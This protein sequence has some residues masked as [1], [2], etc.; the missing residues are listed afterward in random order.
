M[1]AMKRRY[2]DWAATSL[3]DSTLLSESL[4]Q[5]L[6]FSGNP[7]SRHADGK[8]ARE[9][10]EAA[11]ARCALVLGVGADTLYFTSGGTES[12]NLV[13]QSILFRRGARSIAVSAVEHPSVREPLS[14]LKILDVQSAIIPVAASGCVLPDAVKR[15]L[16]RHPDTA[17]Q[18]IMAV[19]NETGAVADI[20]A[21]AAAACECA[22]RKAPHFHCDAVQALGKMPI[23]LK[24]WDVDSA[25]FSAHKIGG[26]R[27]VGLLY[28]RKKFQ[29]LYSGGEQERGLR[30]GTENLFGALAFAAVLEKYAAA[31]VV[32]TNA[33]AASARYARLID[34]LRSIEGCRIVPEERTAMD[35]RFSPY[36]V[37]AA[38]RGIPGEVLVRAMDD[39]GFSISTGSACSSHSRKRS[40]LE[41]MGVDE[42]TALEAVRLSQGF[43]TS[44]EDID[45]LIE[46]LRNTTR[47]LR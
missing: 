40:V 14:R 38:F 11:R 36:I 27:G 30:A 33:A 18:A 5:S 46:G 12:N 26:P 16:T 24:A 32:Q 34:S 15:T 4:S 47:S 25:S 17:L 42:Q 10:L 28:S 43:S 23:D 3:P 6:L 22:G 1:P 35:S 29:V 7:S 19:N 41:A 2:F 20:P 13:L 9:A 31:S 44:D 45:A 37:Q 21:L 39:A 8:A